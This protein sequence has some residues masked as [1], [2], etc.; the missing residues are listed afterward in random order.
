MALL[1]CIFS[2]IVGMTVH[3]NQWM[4]ATESAWTLRTA[5]FLAWDVIYT[6][7]AYAAMSVSVCLWRKCIGT[8]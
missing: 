4:C 3:W 2:G 7:R 8:L 5:L 1:R 6:S